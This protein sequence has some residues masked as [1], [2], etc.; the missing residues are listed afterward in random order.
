MF[1]VSMRRGEKKHG[2]VENRKFNIKAKDHK[3]AFQWG[4]IQA[5][6][7]GAGWQVISVEAAQAVADGQK[8]E[9]K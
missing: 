6:Q 4:K 7:F 5:K 9:L 3:E 2:D 1:C 8:L